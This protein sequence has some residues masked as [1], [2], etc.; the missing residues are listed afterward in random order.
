MPTAACVPSVVPLPETFSADAVPPE[1][2]ARQA[3]GEPELA[4][5]HE[6]DAEIAPEH[7]EPEH[8]HA[9]EGRGGD[10]EA[11]VVPGRAA[12]PRRH[13]RAHRGIPDDDAE[14]DGRWTDRALCELRSHLS[15]RSWW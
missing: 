7:V 5:R 12:R 15:R 10:L 11:R 9:V 3:C 1:F 8:A 14:G 13:V 6:R 4:V 2:E